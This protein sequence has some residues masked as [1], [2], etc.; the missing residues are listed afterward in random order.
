MKGDRARTE[1]LGAQFLLLFA[2][3]EADFY[4]LFVCFMFVI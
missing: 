4:Y 2:N 3:V 1:K